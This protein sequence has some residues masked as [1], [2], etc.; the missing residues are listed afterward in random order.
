MLSC[1]LLLR[2]VFDKLLSLLFCL[3]EFFHCHAAG[4]HLTGGPHIWCPTPI[5]RES[6]R[7]PGLSASYRS[8]LSSPPRGGPS[9]ISQ[10]SHLTL[11]ALLYLPRAEEAF[12]INSHLLE[13]SFHHFFFP[14]QK[15]LFFP[16]GKKKKILSV[17]R[18]VTVTSRNDTQQRDSWVRRNLPELPQ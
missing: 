13:F 5:P 11:R 8:Q 6:P 18:S 9:L 17:K 10:K 4:L 1:P 7:H 15:E 12:Q 3:R 14:S 16:A 2:S